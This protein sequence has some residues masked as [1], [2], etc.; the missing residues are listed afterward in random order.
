VA[1]DELQRV[2]GMELG[3]RQV[4]GGLAQARAEREAE[5]RGAGEADRARELQF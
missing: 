3:A 4:A 5:R 1:L 2:R